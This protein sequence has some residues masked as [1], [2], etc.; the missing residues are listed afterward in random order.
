M[1]QFKVLAGTFNQL[2]KKIILRVIPVIVIMLVFVVIMTQLNPAYK[3]SGVNELLIMIPLMLMAMGVGIFISISRQKKMYESYRLNIGE[4]MISRD[5]MFTPT[6]GISHLEVSQIILNPDNGFT[7]KG[8]TVRDLI[9][10]PAHIENY[11]E[12][13]RLLEAIMPLTTIAKKSF[14]QKYQFLIS[15]FLVALMATVYI[16]SNKILVALCGTAVIAALVYSFF[17]GIKNKNIDNRTR[18]MLWFAWVVIFSVAG[19]MFW[20]LTG[21]FAP[22]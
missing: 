9:I 2:R 15:I 22:H 8:R 7:I 16:S 21:I 11:S 3:G 4:S 20:K 14:F 6:I 12:V 10:V 5:Q 1:P 13:K 17:E 18:V 19:T